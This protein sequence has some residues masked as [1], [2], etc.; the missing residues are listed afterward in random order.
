MKEFLL[1][2]GPNLLFCYSDPLVLTLVSAAIKNR[3]NFWSHITVTLTPLKSENR[4]M[5]QEVLWATFTILITFFQFNLYIYRT[6][7]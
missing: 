7:N 1:V 5:V 6:R 2:L 4:N 3:L